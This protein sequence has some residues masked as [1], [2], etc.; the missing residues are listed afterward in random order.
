MLCEVVG[1]KRRHHKILHNTD[2]DTKK[3]HCNSI[4]STGTYLRPVSVRLHGPTGHVNTYALFDNGSDTTLI[5]SD[6]AKQVGISGTTT[7]LK[8]SSVIG[9]LSQNAELINFEIESL[10]KTNLIRIEGAYAIDNL[11]IKKAEI[12]PTDFQKRWKHLKGV[13]LLAI[14]CDRVGLLLGVDVPE[15]HWVLDQR[16]GKPKQPYASLTMLGWALFGPTDQVS[17]T[18]VFTNCLEAKSSIEDDILKLFEHEF[19]E[20]KYSY[21]IA[22]SPCDKAIVEITD[23]QTILF[24]RNY[25]VPIPWKVDWHSLPKNK[26]EKERRLIHLRKK[27]LKD[28]HFC[29]QYTNIY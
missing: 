21:K 22:M 25:R 7:R 15:A 9:A 28:E 12:P 19:S 3:A 18:S 1:C 13:R 17:K 5:L 11:P 26:H 27:L 8:I 2:P 20:N 24:D 29:K 14:T 6:V 10:D 4:Y 23:K 16:I